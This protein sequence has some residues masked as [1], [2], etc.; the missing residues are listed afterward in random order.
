MSLN[1]ADERILG[2][3]IAPPASTKSMKSS[4]SSQTL[5]DAL[6]MVA[7]H[8]RLELWPPLDKSA[9]AKM[10]QFSLVLAPQ[11]RRT[12]GWETRVIVSLDSE[13]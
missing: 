4:L 3:L 8:R 2:S 6:Q 9:D 13:V 12:K 5:D 10:E 7:S 11:P 1:L